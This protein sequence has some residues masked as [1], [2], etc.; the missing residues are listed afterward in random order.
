MVAPPPFRM[1][2]RG[3]ENIKAPVKYDGLVAYD[4]P[5]EAHYR[6]T[7]AQRRS[8]G[9]RGKVVE[10]NPNLPPA[11]FPTLELGQRR[12]SDAP[13]V[14]HTEMCAT[15][16]EQTNRY[17]PCEMHR[18][19]YS[20]PNTSTFDSNTFR[21]SQFSNS[22][23]QDPTP[24]T[25]FQT[26]TQEV[27]GNMGILAL[28]RSAPVILQSA[29][30]M[31]KKWSGQGCKG[32]DT[33]NNL[34]NP[35]YAD[36][37][38]IMKRFDRRTEEDWNVAEMETS[39]EEGSSGPITLNGTN[40]QRSPEALGRL[41]EEI[42]VALKMD[43][44]DIMEDIFLSR[45]EA[46]HR[47]RLN[48]G[49]RQKLLDLLDRR[50]EQA[51]VEDEAAASL[52]TET[53][54]ILLSRSGEELK[55]VTQT[56]FRQLLKEGL[57]KSIGEDDYYTATSADL[58]RAKEYLRCCGQQPGLLDHWT[59]AL[60][61]G[62]IHAGLDSVES[63]YQPDTAARRVPS[64]SQGVL[65]LA[66]ATRQSLPKEVS[67]INSSIL[68]QPSSQVAMLKNSFTNNLP[69]ISQH[70]L[71]L[72][73]LPKP[74]I[75][76]DPSTTKTHQCSNFDLPRASDIQTPLPTPEV[77]STPK[78]NR[79]PNTQ[80]FH[81]Q[82]ANGNHEGHT[83][84]EEPPPKKRHVSGPKRK[85]VSFA[86]T[87]SPSSDTK[88]NNTESVP[89]AAAERTRRK[90]TIP[91]ST[92]APVATMVAPPPTGSP[93][94]PSISAPL[95]SAPARRTSMTAPPKPTS[96]N[97]SINK[98]NTTPHQPPPPTKS[99]PPTAAPA[100]PAEANVPRQSKST[101]PIPPSH[102][103]ADRRNPK[104]PAPKAPAPA[105]K[106]TAPKAS[107]LK[108][109]AAKKAPATNRKKAAATTPALPKATGNEKG[110][111]A[112]RKAVKAGGGGGS[113]ENGPGNDDGQWTRSGYV[114]GRS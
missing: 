12:E 23:T 43:L 10:F 92:A 31:E 76:P 85:S 28:P 44:V 11:A 58:S 2:T 111:F 61:S 69:S 4:H 75:S 97:P 47:L 100:S 67:T 14:N 20:T 46:M 29:Y 32:W 36:N 89:K 40:T 66:P 38:K 99:P 70:S 79:P 21:C 96:S 82:P 68:V 5:E 114:K 105:S 107:A 80:P 35:V 93:R 87:P 7:V 63:V 71:P 15:T 90:T 78:S 65:E 42:P 73:Q 83:D 72:P 53:M 41:W 74:I 112:S 104:T 60:S 56:G 77:L 95:N 55:R 81:G 86:P 62:S 6:P 19:A 8:L 1:Q 101:A 113:A 18:S 57:Y 13:V 102:T 22:A 45:T 17:L 103:M 48:G 94:N 30:L 9:Y 54:R 91:A 50:E 64:R 25:E 39:D 34:Q 110:K 37:V 16:V 52:R 27:T 26:K 51:V 3:R 98:N 33:S 49:Q 59:S 109:P 88:S 108:A 84:E 24:N 106:A